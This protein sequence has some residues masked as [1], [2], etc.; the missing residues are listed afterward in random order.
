MKD[1]S[2]LEADILREVLSLSNN[3]FYKS[4][5]SHLDHTLW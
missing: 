1:F 4:M 2:F 3:N 5:T